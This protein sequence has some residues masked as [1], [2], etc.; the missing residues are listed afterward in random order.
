[1][2][3]GMILAAGRSARMGQPKWGL[4]HPWA[5]DDFVGHLIQIAQ[6]SHLDPVFV[7]G[8]PDDAPLTARVRESGAI[9]VVNPTADRGQLSS[10]LAG[11]EAA[12]RVGADAIV[13]MP[14]DVPLISQA[15]VEA[16][17]TTAASDDALILRA[18]Y[19]GQH[20]HPVLFKRAVFDELR[21]ADP[22]VGARAV[23]R[24]D[25]HRVID[26]EVDEPGVAFDI[27]TPDDYRRA[28]GVSRGSHA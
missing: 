12:S 19:R 26:V 20:G 18:A 25:P 7:I 5:A 15:V 16:L 17:L 13:V 10:I 8:R 6:K 14:V 3:A 9:L 22:S 2:V 11:L 1:M 21:S 24:A 4:S 27:D 23:V 28:F